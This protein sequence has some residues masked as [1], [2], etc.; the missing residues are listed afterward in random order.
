MSETDRLNRE[1]SVE[2]GWDPSWFGLPPDTWGIILRD[3]I[4]EFQELWGLPPDGYCGDVTIRRMFLDRLGEGQ[5][6]PFDYDPGTDGDPDVTDEI[7]V[8][9]KRCPIKWDRV[10]TYEEQGG[11]KVTKGFSSKKRT[12]KGCVIHWPVTYT[13]KQT[14]AVLNKRGY[15]THFEIGPPIGESGDVTIYQYVDVANKTWHA[16]GANNLVGIDISSPVYAKEKVLNK[17]DRLGHTERPILTGYRVNGWKTPAIVGYHENQLKALYALLGALYSHADIVLD[18]PAHTGNPMR[19]KSLKH[20]SQIKDG[21]FHHAEVDVA[22]R[23]KWDTAG[24][25]LRDAVDR[26]KQFTV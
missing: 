2:Y 8:G 16:V 12:G 13:P 7:I 26:A 19:I 23:G 10:L 1:S 24:I 4:C 9:G 6:V 22:R 15:G 18:A 21:V 5:A 17:L 14:V 25:D 20:K 11:L 3:A